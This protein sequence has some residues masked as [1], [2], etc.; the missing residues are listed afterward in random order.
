[1]ELNPSENLLNVYCLILSALAHQKLNYFSMRMLSFGAIIL[2][3]SL[4]TQD[5]GVQR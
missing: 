1:M 4:E 3:I 5:R 2:N